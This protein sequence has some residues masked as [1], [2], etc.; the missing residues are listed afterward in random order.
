MRNILLFLLLLP[1]L[2]LAQPKSRNPYKLPLINDQNSYHSSMNNDSD[3]QMLNLDTAITGIILDIRYATHNNFTGEII[4]PKAAAWARKPVAEALTKAQK[5]FNKQGLSIKVFDAYRPYAATL[6]FYEVYP[7]TNF[8]AAPW[9][10]SRH[11]RG[12]AVDITLVNLKTGKELPM[13]TTFDDFS[14]KAATDY[15]YLP[16]ELIQNRKLLITTMQRFGFSVYQYEWWHF[17]YIGW[18]K[19]PLMDISFDELEYNQ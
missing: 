16:D 2:L 6:R 7:D 8:V 15:P 19:F 9:H 17:D 11:N 12:A 13:P 4:Y 18:E 14:E 1:G 5:A 10:G 3:M